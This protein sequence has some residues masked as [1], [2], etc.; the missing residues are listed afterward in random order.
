VEEQEQNQLLQQQEVEEMVEDI[1][2]V[3]VEDLIS[4]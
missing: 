3:E 4:L 2:L 1:S